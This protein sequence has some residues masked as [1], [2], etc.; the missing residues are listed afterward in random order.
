MRVFGQLDM[1]TTRFREYG[2]TKS[3]KA[4]DAYG[5]YLLERGEI[6]CFNF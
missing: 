4:F 6:V 5:G 2:T 1:E 3:R